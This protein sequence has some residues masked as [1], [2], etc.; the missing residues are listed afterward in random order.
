MGNRLCL[1]VDLQE[2][3]DNVNREFIYYI[4]HRMGF[5]S[6]WISWIKACIESPSFSIMLNGSPSGFFSSSRGI[7]Q[8]DPLCPYL[9]VMEFGMHLSTLSGNLKA[10]RRGEDNVTHL[11]FADD[12][13]VFC[14]GHQNSVRT[15]N[16]LLEDVHLNTGL[17]INRS[18]SRLFFSKGCTNKDSLA[19]SLGVSIGT[20]PLKYLGLPLTSVY[21]KAKHFVPLLDTTRRK[22]DGWSLNLLS[23]P[24]RLELIKSVLHYLLSYWVFSFR[25]PCSVIKELESIYAKFL[26]NGRMHVWKWSDIC[27]P[28]REGGAGLRRISDIVQAAGV[29]LVWRL[30]STKT[31]WISWMHA[32]YIKGKHITEVD[33]SLIDSGTWKWIVSS[34][35]R[36]LRCMKPV[37]DTQTQSSEIWYWSCIQ[38]S[39]GKC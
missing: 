31:I 34:K 11:L 39:L 8:G 3:F 7:R 15:L 24:G 27:M 37:P 32:Q 35:E 33:A 18:K 5:S 19:N 38:F 25:L 23:F 16:T 17:Q 12:M 29:S 4:M 30:C 22:I 6:K 36:A 2:V 14:R 20:M 21:P 13:L 9:F 26:W 1:K 28:K 10:L